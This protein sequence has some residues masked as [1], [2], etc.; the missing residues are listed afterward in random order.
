[1]PLTHELYFGTLV[2]MEHFYDEAVAPVVV[3]LIYDECNCLTLMGTPS[4]I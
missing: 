3:R 2:R 4:N 1:M